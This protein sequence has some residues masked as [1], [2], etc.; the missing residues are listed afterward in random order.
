[1]AD[2]DLQRKYGLSLG[3]YEKMLQNQ[4][5]HCAICGTTEFSGKGKKPHVDHCHKTGKIRALLCNQ[6][7]VGLG[8]FRDSPELMEAAINYIKKHGD[9][10]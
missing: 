6:C 5:G 8:A 3:E 4:N 7:N 9:T 2:Y 1:M 10:K